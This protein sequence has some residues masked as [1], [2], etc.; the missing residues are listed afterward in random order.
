M[1]KRAHVH[2]HQPVYGAFEF[3]YHAQSSAAEYLE[4][5]GITI[6]TENE[7][8]NVEDADHWEIMIPW[9]DGGPDYGAIRSLIDDLRKHPDKVVG[10]EGGWNLGEEFAGL[11]EEGIESAEKN[12]YDWIFID[13]F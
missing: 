3:T 10:D 11:L 2:V 1:G 5:N 6:S 13:W 4:E 8:A 12:H 7:C 9:N